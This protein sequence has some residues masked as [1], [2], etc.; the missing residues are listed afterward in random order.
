MRA[1]V[2]AGVP[3]TVIPGISSAL[4]APATAGI[5]L[6]H[7][8]VAADFA[9]VSGHLDAA[10]GSRGFDWPTL[11]TGP[12]TIVLL[13][14]MEHLEEIART[15][16]R[17]GRPPQTPAAAVHRATLPGQRIVRSSLQDLAAAVTDAGLSAP[18]VVII[19]DVVALFA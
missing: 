2:E 7:R 9:V 15:L 10:S 12:A 17:H 11:A 1:C 18:S 6:T 19:G 4:A 14:G 5:P 8:G 13:M 16:I 3:V